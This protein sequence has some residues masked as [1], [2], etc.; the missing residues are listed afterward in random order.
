MAILQPRQLTI[1]NGTAYAL[2]PKGLLEFLGENNESWYH[3]EYRLKDSPTKI[4]LVF[5]VTD[6][7]PAGKRR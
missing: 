6:E 7:N 2:M 3:L 5:E 1:I 4:T